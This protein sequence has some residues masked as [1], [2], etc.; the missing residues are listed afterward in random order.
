MGWGGWN[1]PRARAT[2][3]RGLPSLDTRR[4]DHSS[5]PFKMIVRCGLA[6]VKAR[7]GA[8]GL[9]GCEKAAFLSIL[10]LQLSRD[11][12]QDRVIFRLRQPMH[13]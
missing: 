2:R 6:W 4:W 1:D 3:G 11:S 8:P 12:I 13:T 9:G 5:H 10:L 7:L